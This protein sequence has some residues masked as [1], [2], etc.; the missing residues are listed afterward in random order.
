MGRNRPVAAK[1]AQQ[2][3]RAHQLQTSTLTKGEQAAV[4]LARRTPLTSLRMYGRRA[5]PLALPPSKRLFT[6]GAGACDLVI[7][8]DVS[9]KVSGF[10]ATL[11][12]TAECLRVEDQASKNGSF[13]RLSAA[14][15]ASFEA[16]AGRSF[17]LADVRLLPMDTQLEV[18]RPAL[19]WHLGLDRDDA[20]DD[21]I[22]TIAAG[23]PLVLEGPTGSES[24]ELARAIHEASAQRNSFLLSV[25]S[26]PLASLDAASGGTVVVDLAAVRKLPAPYCARLFNPRKALRP[27]FLVENAETVREHIDSYGAMTA[28]IKLPPLHRRK[29]EILRLVAMDWISRGSRRCVDELGAGTAGLAKAPWTRN[30]EDL[31]Q[32]SKRLLALLESGSLRSA[33][34]SLGITHQSLSAYF[35]RIGFVA[36]VDL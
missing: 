26:E 8:R 25:A 23:G 32:A 20:I 17:W 33:A 10:H 7:P 27:I 35:Q 4:T 21:A 3:P 16:P 22:E 15:L 19:A 1:P 30:F 36:R 34:R 31:R 13:A 18:L 9:T 29:H 2:P 11:T 28:T 24:L 14:R 6:I 12:R 5:V